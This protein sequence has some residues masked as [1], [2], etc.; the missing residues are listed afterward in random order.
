M[1]ASDIHIQIVLK[2]I[3]VGRLFLI[4][5]HIKADEVVKVK[6]CNHHISTPNIKPGIRITALA[7]HAAASI[8]L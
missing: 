5:A 1:I 7:S 6:K 8:L 4:L 3:K 2:A